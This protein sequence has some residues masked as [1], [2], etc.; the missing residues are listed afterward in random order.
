[1]P[2]SATTP[3]AAL[4]KQVNEPPPPLR[5]VNINIPDWLESVVLKAL[6]KSPQDR[7]QRASD[8]AEALRQ[9]RG[10]ER[11]AAAGLAG[12]ARRT[13]QRVEHPEK[14]KRSVVP[15]LVGGIV[16]LLLILL[17]VA[18][19]LVWGGGTG[20]GGP[21]PFVTK[22]VPRESGDAADPALQSSAPAEWQVVEDDVNRQLLDGPPTMGVYRTWDPQ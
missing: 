17:A 1:V 14:A 3:V 21:T 8:F 11:V 5:Q 19:Y 7:Y 15:I 18:A 22:V 16:V 9:H 20:P 10:P 12:P 6:A 2:F 13:P 4:Y